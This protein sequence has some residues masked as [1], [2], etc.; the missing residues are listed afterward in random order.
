[1]S[2]LKPRQLKERVSY[3]TSGKIQMQPIKQQL[4]YFTG[5]P[6]LLNYD[7]LD[8]QSDFIGR[9][10]QRATFPPTLQ[11]AKIWAEENKGIY[12]ELLKNGYIKSV[13]DDGFLASVTKYLNRMPSQ[14]LDRHR[15]KVLGLG[16]RRKYGVKPPKPKP[17]AIY[18]GRPDYPVAQPIQ[19][20]PVQDFG[21]PIPEIQPP[22]TI[23]PEQ[24]VSTSHIKT[25]EV[26][27]EQSAPRVASEES[28][29]EA[30]KDNDDATQRKFL[31]ID[32]KTGMVIGAI[33]LIGAGAFVYFKYFKK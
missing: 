26:P 16:W 17:F 28:M 30:E 22:L 19:P 29:R 23:I 2:N 32:R 14:W 9:L 5:N 7:L 6:D 15:D 3:F 20:Q 11:E 21:T 24:P 33:V 13:D 27:S 12:D 4:F 8:E 25:G 18:H 31:G 10:K 1:M